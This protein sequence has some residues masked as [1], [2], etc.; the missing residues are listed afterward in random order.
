MG[1]IQISIISLGTTGLVFSLILAFLSKKLEVK[2]DPKLE[3]VLAVLPHINCGACGF[4]GCRP[5]AEAVIDQHKLFNGCLPGGKEVNNKIA[6]IIGLSD[7]VS[8]KEKQIVTCRCGASWNEKKHSATY[9]G[10]S[11]CRG[12]HEVGGMIDCA[13]GC[14]GLGDC[15]E[16]CPVDA[17]SAVENKIHVDVN[18]CIGCGNCVKA[19]PRNL[20]Q[21][22]PFKDAMYY[23]AC[24]NPEKA[25]Y[26]KSVCSKGCIGCGICVRVEDSPFYLKGSLSYLDYTKESSNNSSQE[27]AKTK[28]PT[29]CILKIDA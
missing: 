27:Q 25:L 13:Y 18:K 2:D 5:F 11:T 3:E 7:T 6:E 23:V 20:F 22:R 16:V 28:C 12:A 17:I 1:T 21:F 26:V 29:K 10:P 24:N 19:C 8:S 9:N 4:H 14:L 15:V